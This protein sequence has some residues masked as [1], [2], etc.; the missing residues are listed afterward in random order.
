MP[1]PSERLACIVEIPKGSR[2]KY[3]W[4]PELRRIRLDRFLFSSVAYPADVGYFPHT[5]APDG[6]PLDAIVCVSE[7][8]FPGCWIAVRVVA[9]LRMRDE[10]GL[11]DKI[12]CVPERDPNWSDVATLED[13]PEQLRT[14]I[15]HFFSIYKQPE[16][17]H[18]QIE[19]WLPREQALD[20]ID[21]ATR[22]YRE[23][24]PRAAVSDQ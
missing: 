6:E 19:G 8:T 17:L 20:V 11:D 4:D 16:G 1:P 21:D 2:N 22:R 10:M 3:A 5:L 14:E 13:L 9:L 24:P 18:V 15:A 7:A 12:V 23:A